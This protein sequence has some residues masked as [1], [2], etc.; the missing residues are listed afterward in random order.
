MSMPT[1]SYCLEF[2]SKDAVDICRLIIFGCMS[3]TPAANLI[4]PLA[5][6]EAAKPSGGGIGALHSPFSAASVPFF[7]LECLPRIIVL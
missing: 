1:C 4:I 3:A 6:N 7:R 5:A 2:I